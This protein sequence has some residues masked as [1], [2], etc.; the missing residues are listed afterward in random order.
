M[1]VSYTPGPW[2]CSDTSHHAHDYRLGVPGG[3]MPFEGN[4]VARANARLIAAAPDLLGALEALHSYTR[5][6]DAPY[7]N[8]LNATDPLYS[9]VHSA[10]AAAK[11]EDA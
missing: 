11:G 6:Q 5:E 3:R 1:T 10:I 4:E 2:T 9:R 8:G 7:R